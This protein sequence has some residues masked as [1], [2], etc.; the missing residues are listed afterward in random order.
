M[1]DKKTVLV[2]GAGGFVGHHVVEHLLENTDWDVVG[3]YTYTHHGDPWRLEH[4][5]NDPRLSL[6][7]LDCAAPWGTIGE[8]LAAQGVDYVLHLAADSH[9]DRSITDPVPFVQNNVNLTLHTMEWAKIAKPK[10]FIQ[11]STDEVYGPARDKEL[12]AEWSPI[13]P[14]N[15]YSASKAAQE[16]IAISYWRTYDVPLIITNTMNVI[17]ERQDMEKFVP[18]LIRGVNNGIV[19]PIHAD[20]EGRP[21]SRFY[22]HARNVADALMFIINHYDGDYLLYKEGFKDRPERFN[23]VGEVEI[24]NL[25]LGLKVASNIGKELKY[26]LLNFHAARPGHDRRYALDGAK[27]ASIGWA[28]PVDFDE[29]LR[30]TINW[31]LKNRLWVK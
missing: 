6:I 14:S 28:P 13:V 15:P 24:D 18:M 9:V 31:E 8:R 16:A 17:G 29:S 20:D 3:T 30:R 21:G 19:I 25:T 11:F 5:S 26:E 12:H 22:I 10:L 27:L 4:L 2:T 23:I 7:H 1:T